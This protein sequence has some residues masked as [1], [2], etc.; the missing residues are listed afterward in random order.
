[1]AKS[2]W[3][4]KRVCQSC[5]TLF[6][7]FAKSPIVCPSCGAAFDPEAV[8][9]SRRNRVPAPEQAKPMRPKAKEDAADLEDED[10]NEAE[11]NVLADEDEDEDDEILPRIDDENPPAVLAKDGDESEEDESDDA[12]EVPLA[13]DGET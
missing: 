13:D 8:L 4:I 10:E 7:D 12:A 2:E 6:Y 9:K 5:A 11:E 3:G 1:M